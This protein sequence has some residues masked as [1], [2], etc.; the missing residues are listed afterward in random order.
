M[1]ELRAIAETKIDGV[2]MLELTQ[3]PDERGSFTEIYRTDW[4]PGER[5]MVQSNL[6]FS[7][8]GVL[9]GLHFHRRQTDY[10]VLLEGHAFV[11][12][13]DLRV[14]SPTRGAAAGISL[15]AE[16]SDRALLIPPG[17]AHGFLAESKVRLLYLVDAVYD[18][19]DE[20]G[21]AWNDPDV[22]IEWPVT[23]PVLSERDRGNPSLAEVLRDPPH[24]G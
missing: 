20:F 12:L 17:V 14:G 6:S 8:P 4:I 9:R 5:E 1:N 16:S 10:W 23:D 11:G 21:I 7:R 2:M 3:H 24:M 13:Y 19:A 15:V 18:G 22:G